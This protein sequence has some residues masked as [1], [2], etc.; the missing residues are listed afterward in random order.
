MFQLINMCLNKSIFSLVSLIYS[1]F[2]PWSWQFWMNLISWFGISHIWK[3][4]PF[5]LD[6][7]SDYA[8]LSYDFCMG[9]SCS[10]LAPRHW[11]RW[12]NM[13]WILCLLFITW[14][15]TSI[16]LF[17]FELEILNGPSW[18]PSYRTFCLNMIFTL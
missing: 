7:Y 3:W 10:I 15:F 5:C 11:N 14:I 12:S 9:L 2:L 17:L 1:F 8:N 16:L 18:A 6:L 4:L 13:I